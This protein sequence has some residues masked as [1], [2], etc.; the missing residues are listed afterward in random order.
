[1]EYLVPPVFF[2]YNEP[3]IPEA[4]NKGIRYL[5]CFLRGIRNKEEMQWQHMKLEKE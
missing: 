4:K 2:R 1:M 3:A 5:I